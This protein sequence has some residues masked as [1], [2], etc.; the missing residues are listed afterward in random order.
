MSDLRKTLT[1]YGLLLATVSA[2]A[3]LSAF[4]YP[5]SAKLAAP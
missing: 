4:I 3:L 1:F 5:G 2:A